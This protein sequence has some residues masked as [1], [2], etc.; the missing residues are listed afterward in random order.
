MN[1]GD[2]A[3]D[4]GAAMAD[5]GGGGTQQLLSQAEELA[6]L[7]EDD[8]ED[9]AAGPSD[10]G[11]VELHRQLSGSLSPHSPR[12]GGGNWKKEH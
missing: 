7:D 3:G 8:L 5:D 6:S 2:D 9:A 12:T 1:G 10:A 11:V 4:D